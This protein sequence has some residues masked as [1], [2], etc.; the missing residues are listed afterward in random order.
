MAAEAA[1]RGEQLDESIPREG[2]VVATDAEP[3]PR[4]SKKA[5]VEPEHRDDLDVVA[6]EGFFERLASGPRVASFSQL[7]LS[8]PLLG[9]IASL[10]WSQP[11]PVQAAVIPTA[12]QGRD[13]CASAPTGSGKTAAFVVPIV[14]RLMHR[15][16]AGSM[17]AT[18]VLI[19]LPTR[20]LAAQCEAV[21]ARLAGA[22]GITH[23]LCVGGV[24]LKAQESALRQRPD[25]VVATPGRVVDHLLNSPGWG[26]E[27]VEI[28]V[29]DECD[30]LLD[31]GFADQVT[32]VLERVPRQR[33][34]LLF[35]ATLTEDVSRLAKLALVRPVRVHV[36]ARDRVPEGLRQEFVR[37]RPE[38]EP[39]LHALALYLCCGALAQSRTVLFVSKRSQAH[40]L[41]LLLHLAGQSCVELRGDMPHTH[42]AAALEDFKTGRARLLVATDLAARGLDV[43][44]IDAVV[45]VNM[46]K[47]LREY[48]HRV[49]RT[50]RAGLSG[51]AISLVC[52]DDRATLKA[53]LKDNTGGDSIQ[54]RRLDPAL[55]KAWVERVDSWAPHLSLIREEEA[56]E[57]E[58]KKG[59]ME[60]RRLQNILEHSKEILSRPKREW[61]QSERDKAEAKARYLREQLGLLEDKDVEHERAATQKLTAAEARD[62]RKRDKQ[63]LAALE[64]AAANKHKRKHGDERSP[65]ELAALRAAK[66]AAKAA[67]QPARDEGAAEEGDGED[68]L[69]HFRTEEDDARAKLMRQLKAP[70]QRRGGEARLL[71]AQAKRAKREA[72]ERHKARSGH[73]EDHKRGSFKVRV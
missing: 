13:V 64:A 57:E 27:D 33:Q 26:L 18:R 1:A 23:A 39:H 28:L 70:S 32:A 46:P 56:M 58:L 25:I 49:G 67:A 34:T 48:V 40:Q 62:K 35:S 22:S 19:L 55:V 52:E 36:P 65:E 50:A 47:T 15:A 38:M 41:C 44:A 29:L 71:A 43:P 3:A 21:V 4:P 20:E 63:E 45:N 11:T 10:R 42:R 61:F 6:P 12:L 37:V 68:L 31:L 54:R 73:K 51:R 53:L 5:A 72:L 8:R 66:R 59:Q 30:R 24:S 17:G 7:P 69:R 9:I 60:V 14:E 2:A 16:R